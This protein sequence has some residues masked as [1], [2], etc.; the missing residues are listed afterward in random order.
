MQVFSDYQ[1][2]DL[3]FQA[4]WSF[5]QERYLGIPEFNEADNFRVIQGVLLANPRQMKKYKHLNFRYHHPHV[6][7]VF[8]NI[9]SIQYGVNEGSE[10]D[11]VNQRDT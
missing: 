1:I 3:E 2:E 6:G 11:L 8:C 9:Y 10:E 7:T 5:S 4:K